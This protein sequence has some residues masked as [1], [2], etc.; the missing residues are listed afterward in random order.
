ML[1]FCRGELK[2]TLDFPAAGAMN[3]IPLPASAARRS[4]QSGGVTRTRQTEQAI[5][6]T[7]CEAKASPGH[8]N[9]PPLSA[10]RENA[11]E[12]DAETERQIRLHIV[13][14]LVTARGRQ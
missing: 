1:R 4:A 2:V 12:G 13:M 10:R 5:H 9:P 14:R 7:T 8:F 6:Q 11:L 3:R